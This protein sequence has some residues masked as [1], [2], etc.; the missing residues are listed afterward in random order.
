MKFFKPRD[1]IDHD[2][3]SKLY[4]SEIIQEM[5]VQLN[6]IRLRLDKLEAQSK[7]FRERIEIL[8]EQQKK[9]DLK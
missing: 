4:D 9:R 3:E 7:T 1:Q 6:N 8:E 2:Y 5:Y